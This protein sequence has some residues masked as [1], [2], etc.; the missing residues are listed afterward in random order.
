MTSKSKKSGDRP[1]MAETI[2]RA[3]QESGDSVAAVARGAGVVQPV[4][5][6]FMAGERDLTL[7]VADRLVRYFNL[8]LVHQGKGT[9]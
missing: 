5:H 2:R 4:L 8:R 3:V 9:R 6:R 1:T 7:R